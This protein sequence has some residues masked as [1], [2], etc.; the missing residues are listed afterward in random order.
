MEVILLQDM[1]KLGIRGQ[2]V[3]VADGYGRN[4]LLPKKLAVAA[5]AQ[6]RK[7][8]E[9]QRIRFLKQSAKEKAEAE[10][11]ARLL[12][13]V[14][15]SFTRRA[16]EQGTL[17]GSVT[18][19]DIAEGLHAQGYNIDRRKIHVDPPIKLLGEYDVTIKL[20]RE[21]TAKIKVKVEGEI[22]AAAKE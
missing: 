9:Q 4:Y 3:T 7:W 14:S 22:E 10:D 21:V 16:G 6:N 8:I 17:F 19:M 20:H 11:L 2:I 5:T 18:A 12:A 15:V 13:D 1:E